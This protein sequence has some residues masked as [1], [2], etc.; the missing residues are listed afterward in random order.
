[1]QRDRISKAVR[2]LGGT[3]GAV[4]LALGVAELVTHL[5]EPLSLFFW[6]PA[7]WG[8]AALVLVGV[9]ASAARPRLSLVFMLVGAFVGLL[10]T[11]WT[12]VMP[13]LVFAFVILVVVRASRGSTT[14]APKI[15]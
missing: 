7:L 15:A 6:L 14:P 12:V 11:A 10:A 4:F 13:V 3:I 9:F 2:A 1:M 5:D 8:G